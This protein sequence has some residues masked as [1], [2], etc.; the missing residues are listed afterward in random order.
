MSDINIGITGGGF[1][2][3]NLSAGDRLIFTKLYGIKDI[4]ISVNGG[5]LA[6]ERGI[7]KGASNLEMK[8]PQ[9]GKSLP[10]ILKVTGN[11]PDG[12]S[13]KINIREYGG[14][15]DINYF[16]IVDLDEEGLPIYADVQSDPNSI[17]LYKKPIVDGK[18]FAARILLKTVDNTPEN[19]M[20]YKIP[21][22]VE[23][24]ES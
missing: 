4:Y 3:A 8:F 7:A 22:P 1:P 20:L 11:S 10:C 9:L 16:D 5:S 12:D 17:Q 24:G 23:I 14:I 21:E 6:F 19:R 13:V 2:K 15:P 18:T